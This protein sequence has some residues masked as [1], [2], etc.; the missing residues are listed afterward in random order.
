MSRNKSKDIREARDADEHDSLDVESFRSEPA[1]SCHSDQNVGDTERLLSVAAGVGLG[2]VGLARRGL[3]GLGLTAMGAGLLWRGYTGRCQCYAALGINT[4]KRKPSTAVPAGQ[5]CKFEKSIVI[6]CEPEELYRF[7]RRFEN[8]PQVM[9]HLK[10]VQT[11]D[12][13]RSHWVAEGALGKDVQWDAE[14]INEREN[15]MI[16]WRSLPGGDIE[17]AGS[18]HFEPLKN[19]HGSEVTVSMKFN[20]PV[21]KIGAQVASLIGEGLEDKLDE[22]LKTFKQVMET[23]MHAAPAIG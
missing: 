10:S 5:G 8:L 14:I 9:R 17:T 13:E 1:E 21:G 2:L 20:P 18:V 7:W 16:A 12:H 3:R 6:D 22:D 15:E 19:I 4:A 23:G 11:I